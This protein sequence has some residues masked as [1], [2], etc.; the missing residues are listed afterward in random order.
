MMIYENDKKY[1]V[2]NINEEE[3][4]EKYN[5]MLAGCIQGSRTI[6]ARDIIAVIL[7]LINKNII[8]FE[9]ESK[10]KGKDAY[11]YIITKN[12]EL[13]NQMDGMEKFIYEWV[14]EG[15][16]KVNLQDRLT[17][18]PKEKNANQNFK[19][20]NN[21]V[22]GNL[23]TLGANQAKVPLIVRGFNIFLFILSIVLIAKH[24][25]FNGFE[26]YDSQESL[27]I[28]GYFIEPLI[29]L[30]PLIMGILYIPINLIIMIRHKI[31]K[32]VQK[33]TGQ[34]VATTTISLLVL[35]GVI[36]ILTAI[37]VEAKYIIADEILICIA[38]ILILTDNLML[39][40]SATMIED[41]S[42]L[43]SLKYKIENYSMMEDKDVEQITLWEKYLSYAVSFGVASKIV[44]RLQGLH[45]DE[46]L[47]NLVSNEKFVDFITSDYYMFYRYASLDR[48]FMK[49]Y[50]ET[51]GKMFKA[52]GS[53]SGSSSGGGRRILWRW[54]LLR[55][56][57]KRP[58]AVVPSSFGIKVR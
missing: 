54:R 20:L 2:N 21:L 31:N 25:M 7:N 56:R 24:I 19:H 29:V 44:K 23:A 30:L 5:P 37:F 57:R 17:Q 33:V 6:L 46:D 26:I 28:L 49:A 47:L 13:E 41:Y 34:K 1:I 12:K 43:N 39:K 58:E 22:E 42:K 50:G 16:E 36:I 48:R 18:M 3:L 10:L 27:K 38:T 55:R 9:F 32:T 52:M 11:N 14:F 35:F 15:K 51:T 53:S 8:K 40:N 45:L 4:F